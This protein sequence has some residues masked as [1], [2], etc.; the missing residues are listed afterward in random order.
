MTSETG[1][2]ASPS[3][4]FPFD[5]SYARLPDGFFARLD[6]ARMPEPELIAFNTDLATELGLDPERVET[7]SAR[8]LSGAEL[9]E[10]A[11]PIAM[12]YAGHQFGNFVPQLGDGRAILLGEIVDPTGVRRDIQL[13]GSGQ[14]PFSRM[15]DGRAAIGPVLREYIVSEAM[16]AL[17]VPTTRSLAAV[18]T[19]ETVLRERPLPGAVLTRVGRSHV[20]VG[21][22]QYF[23]ARRDGDAIRIL[24]DYVIDRHYPAAK[25]A[26]N[27]YVALL[28]GVIKAQAE[29]VVRWMQIGF[30]HGVMNTDN[31]S[32][33]GDTIDY[34]PC[35]FMDTY[36]PGKVFSSIDHM[37]RY[38]Y[39]NQP[40]I[41]HWN[42]YRLAETLLHLF[43][44]EQDAAIAAAETV[45][46]KYQ[47]QYDAAWLAGMRKKLG[48]T[49][50]DPNDKALI[51]GFLE[52]MSIDQTDFTLSFRHLSKALGDDIDSNDFKALFRSRSKIEQWLDTWKSRLKLE[53][54]STSDIA[55]DMDQTNP[56]VIPRNHLVE[57]AI[58]DAEDNMD[59]ARFHALMAAIRAP[60]SNAKNMEHFT[61]PPGREE[62]VYQTFCGT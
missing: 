21:T 6:P 37:G 1:T 51:E 4:V 12:A 56:A 53:E 43:A 13:K 58:A 38:A 44:D 30:I 39:S 14:T 33:T 7:Q 2:A 24:A 9:P 18:K 11:S 8:I 62:V 60:F 57:Q 48:L 50:E 32:I 23:A 41:A 46:S 3:G 5:N 40:G 20:R 31:A 22:F 27:P 28:E 34:G 47:E 49:L 17:G 61:K 35:A 19:G 52:L 10:G 55:I 15:G 59:F 16:N 25:E 42:L 29:L 45:L 36:H 26:A 54:R